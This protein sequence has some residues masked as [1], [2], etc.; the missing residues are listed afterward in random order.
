M[1]AF[2]ERESASDLDLISAARSGD[3][4]AVAELYVRHHDAAARY[5]RGLAD[6]TTAEDLVAEA[7]AKLLESIR[8]G[9][10]PSV[11]FRPYLLRTVHNVYVNHVRR[12][13]RHAWV[14]D[15]DELDA[16]LPDATE[17][18]QESVVLANAF[19]A[20]P[21][22]W[23]AVLWHTAV[24]GE[25]HET[26][27]RLLGL[28]ANAV[29]ALAFR[30]REGLRS[31]YLEAHL[32]AVRDEA[33]RPFRD[34]LA[35]YVRG[36]VRGRRRQRLEEHLAGCPD[37]TAGFLELNALGTDLG[38]VL[39]PALLGASAAAYVG[40]TAGAG[41]GVG[42]G[43]FGGRG[44]RTSLAVAGAV[45]AVAALAGIGF[46][47]LAQGD[48][49]DDTISAGPPGQSAGTVP[50]PEASAPS[51]SPTSASAESTITFP[52]PAEATAPALVP[53]RT[54]AP[55]TRPDPR[56]TSEPSTT[57][58][59]TARPSSSPT[60]TATPTSPPVVPPALEP[61]ETPTETPKETPTETP[62]ETPPVDPK[63]QE[64]LAIG[65]GSH[66]YYGPH[67]HVQMSVAALLDPTVI[68]LRVHRL[69][70]FWVH[71]ES[72]YL[73]MAE[74][75]S[76]CV[77]RHIDGDLSELTCRISVSPP[78]QGIFAIDLVVAGELDVVARVSA[79]DNAD[80]NPDND[81]LEFRS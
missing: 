78:R 37:C 70:S 61:S 69:E 46:A 81:E 18:R 1:T 38:A 29:A 80:P 16:P 7:F 50:A 75:D 25:D 8:A 57:P 31:A 51:A 60:P 43:L 71:D 3:D 65:S 5:A 23:Q 22:R 30:S 74:P 27:G 33:C 68:T 76:P 15:A 41:T 40:T 56:P 64:D 79:A 47:L 20:L 34:Q 42:V 2:L 73:P 52:P 49:P 44:L 28:K 59:P 32:G 63:T 54:P 53:T 67:H 62:T 17:Q 11:A 58:S 35:P 6:P 26:V 9:G 12:D 24:E 66:T 36:R 14:E 39:A 10:G 55:S 48:E 45:A 72:S 21:E 77:Q 4:E 19:A 13:S